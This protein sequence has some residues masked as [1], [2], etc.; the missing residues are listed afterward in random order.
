MAAL[1]SDPSV[2]A[3]PVRLD[4]RS[5]TV[6]GVLEPSI[7]APAEIEIIANVVTSPH[8]LSATMVTGRV[9]RMTE[10]GP[11]APCA[12]TASLRRTLLAESLLRCGAGPVLGV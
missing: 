5:A 4:S 12:N 6:I 8:H 2:L 3:K 1:K 10:L 9:H 11:L 7:P